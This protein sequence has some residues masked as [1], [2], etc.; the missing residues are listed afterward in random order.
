MHRGEIWWAEL[1]APQGT[2]PVILMSRERAIQIR[3]VVTI[4][5]ITS[6][7]RGIPTEV[8][9]GP[10]DGLPKTC[11]ANVDS[12]DTIPKAFLRRRLC[13]LKGSKMREVAA[14]IRFAL[15]LD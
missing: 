9:L 3:T 13:V 8:P 14:A 11:V 6:T 2:R 10:E 7:S 12:L 15:G 5:P 4:C 1:P